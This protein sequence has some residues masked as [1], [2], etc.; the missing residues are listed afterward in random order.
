MDI[1]AA[2]EAIPNSRDREIAKMIF[3]EDEEFKTVADRF[4]RSV[5]YVYTVKNRLI[6]QLKSR[7]SGYH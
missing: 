5:D 3:L 4:D 2:I 7:L 6:R 1:D